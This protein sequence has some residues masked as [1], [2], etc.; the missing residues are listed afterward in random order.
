MIYTRR[1]VGTFGK[2]NLWVQLC[3]RMKIFLLV[4]HSGLSTLISAPQSNQLGDNK[5]NRIL[6]IGR[7]RLIWDEK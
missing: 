7:G 4:P 2:G 6:G 1:E 5:Y 3:P